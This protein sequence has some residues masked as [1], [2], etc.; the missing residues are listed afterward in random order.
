M[1][2]NKNW[3]KEDG[4][5]RTRDYRD[6]RTTLGIAGVC[7]VDQ[8]EYRY[9]GQ[10]RLVPVAVIELCVADMESQEHPGGVREGRPPS[11]RFFEGVEAKVAPQR[12]QGQAL[13]LLSAKLGVPL[14][15]VVYISGRLRDGVWMHRCDSP[16]GKWKQVSLEAFKAGLGRL[17][18]ADGQ[19]SVQEV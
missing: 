17:G 18:K 7:D 10:G 9:D 5:Q 15:L 4:E 8:I 14:Y 1:T 2:L 3:S 11:P 13:R 19:D 6:W 12:S 16:S